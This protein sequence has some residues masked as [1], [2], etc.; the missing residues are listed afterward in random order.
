MHAQG[1]HAGSCSTGK[2][3]VCHMEAENIG[4]EMTLMSKLEKE[5]H[6][7]GKLK[8]GWGNYIHLGA[9]TSP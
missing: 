6:K 5:Y 2:G 4:R 8:V 7:Q 9:L 1:S 3:N